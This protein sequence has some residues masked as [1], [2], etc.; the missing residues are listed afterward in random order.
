MGLTRTVLIEDITGNGSLGISIAAGTAVDKA[1][2]LAPAAGPSATFVVDNTPPTISVSSPSASYTTGG[3]IDYTVTYADANFASSSLVASDITLDQT[4]TANGQ[5]SVSG[6]GLS[7]T[8]AIGGIAGDGTLGISIAAGTA[9]DLASNK[10][11][12]SGPSASFTVNNTPPTISISPP[13]ESYTAGGPIDYTVTYADANFA[14]SNLVASDI[15]LDE[16]GTANGQVSVSGS[17]LSYTVAIGGITGDGT[18]GISIA[19][20]TATDLAGNKAPA[21]GTSASFTV[22][23]TPPTI[24][25]SP[26]SESYTTGGPIDYTVTY[27]DANFASSNLV[28]SDITLDQTGTA[29]GQVSVSGSGLSYTVAIGGITG[30]G[31]LGISITARTATDLAGNKAPA[32]GPSATVTVNTTGPTLAAAASATPDPVTGTSAALAVLGA[33]IATG[34]P[35][36]TYT[37][38]A[39][40]YPNGAAPSLSLDNGS[41]AAQNITALFSRAGDYTFQVTIADP[42]GLS[43]TSSVDV[44]V[45]QTLE[46]IVVS[47]SS[48]TLVTGAAEQFTGTADDQFG[49]ALSVQPALTWSVAGSGGIDGN[50]LYTAPYA[51]GSATVSVGLAGGGGLT[52]T[53]GVTFSGQAPQWTST[54]GSSWAA[55]GN[56][57]DEGTGTIL[58]AAPGVRGVVGDTAS[59]NAGGLAGGTV[60]L[61]GANPNLASISLDSGSNGFTLAAGEPA[62]TLLLENG[63]ASANIAVVGSQ[64]IST[65][66]VL[67]SSVE[68]V[69]TA[70]SQLTISG[71]I[72][73]TGTSLT[74]NGDGTLILSGANSYGG[75]TVSDGVLVV[76]NSSALGGG[77]S[78]MVRA[79]A[80][81]LFGS[82]LEASPVAAV[83]AAPA[84]ISTPV[85]SANTTTITTIAPVAASQ[86]SVSPLMANAE[87]L[88]TE[89]LKSLQR[90]SVS[91]FSFSQCRS[92]AGYLTW[93]AQ[94]TSDSYDSEQHAKGLRAIQALDAVF[95]QYG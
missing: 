39:T 40:T 30:D 6:S 75:T 66:V 92:A 24:S 86:A 65:P 23:N 54:N 58:P 11:P 57:E 91:V 78:L 81:L 89:T 43:T 29:N 45:S 55:A 82:P 4:G 7:Y 59:F 49:N 9:T 34:E 44:T 42:F 48:A 14:S 94:A 13:S 90:F 62:G 53:A 60:T 32:S 84:V 87:T 80:S 21:S 73:G 95:A 28:A 26:P 79:G 31:T 47:P 69:P 46:S 1:G 83:S 17:G 38:V 85:T 74:L 71:P 88:K 68:V 2:N 50:G 19:A 8:V 20:G 77:S 93:L 63:T 18:L 37:W 35:S 10:A 25:I 36:L 51:S 12:A 3:P 64:T 22:N 70:G 15:T 27:A 41:N 61:D 5:V 72:S 56:W 33:D 76:A 67:D 16:T 52:A